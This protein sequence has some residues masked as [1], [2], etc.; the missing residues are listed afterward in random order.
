MQVSTRLTIVIQT[1]RNHNIPTWIQRCL[2]SV[3]GWAKLYD[4]DYVLHGDEFYELCGSEYLGRGKKGPQTITDLARLIATRQR[5]DEGYSRVIWMDADMFVFN[6]SKFTFDFPDEQLATGYAVGREVL[7]WREPKGQF[8]TSGPMCHNAAML[9]TQR[10]VDLDMLITLVRHIDANRDVFS[11]FQV[12]VQ[13]LRGLQYS[14]MFPTLSH[15]ALFSPDLIRA[16][17]ERDRKILRFY[18]EAYRYPAYAANLSLSMQ[19]PTAERVLRRA[20]DRLENDGGETLNEHATE[21]GVHLVPC[22]YDR[23]FEVGV[24]RL[25]DVWRAG[26]RKLARLGTN[27]SE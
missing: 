18:C 26:L 8:Y 22:D 9:F 4:Y 14:F 5:L 27:G 3:R 15:A 24:R 23:A 19:S 1:F 12:G 6:P 17:A 11:A 25:N 20:M 16:I 13:L 21:T 10:A 7:L 2:D